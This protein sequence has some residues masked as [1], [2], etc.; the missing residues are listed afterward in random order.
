[1]WF[2]N[3]C[4]RL[5]LTDNSFFPFRHTICCYRKNLNWIFI[6]VTACRVGERRPTTLISSREVIE[7]LL[8]RSW[9]VLTTFCV[10]DNIILIESISISRNS[11]FWH[12]CKNYFFIFIISPGS[13]G[14]VWLHLDSCELLVLFDSKS[15]YWSNTLSL[16]IFLKS[17]IVIFNNF[18]NK[19]GAG[20]TPK[21]R[22]KKS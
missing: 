20:P 12:R 10:N 5:L 11:V 16:F 19:H 17:E 2:L 6:V 9:K 21:H 18:V 8:R 13:A 22:H 3:W 1:M 7:W 15:T 4:L 14:D